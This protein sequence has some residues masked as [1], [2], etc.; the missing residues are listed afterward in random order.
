MNRTMGYD[1]HNISAIQRMPK[2]AFFFWRM[3]GRGRRLE[4]DTVGTV[5]G[6]GKLEDARQ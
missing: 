3:R 2:R 4:L 5:P 1:D 6:N